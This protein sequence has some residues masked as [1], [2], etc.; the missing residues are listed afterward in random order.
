MGLIGLKTDFKDNIK[1][2]NSSINNFK[3]N[4]SLIKNQETKQLIKVAILKG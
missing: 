2:A 1:A 4:N 3:K